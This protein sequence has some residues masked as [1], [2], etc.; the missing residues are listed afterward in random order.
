MSKKQQV[1]TGKRYRAMTDI[2]TNPHTYPGDEFNPALV[3]AE[4][5]EIFLKL[6]HVV[7]ESDAAAGENENG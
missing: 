3:S 6:G 4:A 7:E 2:N 1:K 5:L